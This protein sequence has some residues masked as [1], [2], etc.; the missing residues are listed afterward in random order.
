MPSLKEC[1][2][3]YDD[4]KVRVPFSSFAFSSSLAHGHDLSPFWVIDSA[5]SVNLT[6][7]ESG[8][9]TFDPP[10]VPSRVGGV[11]VNVKGS[12]TVR[13]TIPLA[14]GLSIHRTVH[15]LYP[16]TCLLV[17]LIA[18]VAFS[19]FDGCKLTT[20]VNSFSLLT[21]ILDCSWCPK[22]WVC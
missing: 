2:D 21:S 8:F 10:F 22:E 11:G 18:S 14:Y 19:L 16:L 3:E 20:V 7:F 6:T 9:V 15:A 5:C 17:V 1:T 12:G 13:I 4:T